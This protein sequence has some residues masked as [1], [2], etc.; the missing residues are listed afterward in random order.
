MKSSL[1]D[2]AKQ[3]SQADRRGALCRTCRWLDSLPD[4]ERSE[5]EAAFA[6]PLEDV[7]HTVLF[8]LIMERWPDCGMTRDSMVNHRRGRCR[9]AR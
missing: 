1:L 9:G 2:A 4:D 3:A 8:D 6:A 5:V 7:K